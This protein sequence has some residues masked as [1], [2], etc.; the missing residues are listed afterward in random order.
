[1]WLETCGFQA[2]Q[3]S[4]ERVTSSSTGVG[5]GSMGRL[6]Q[7]SR[8]AYSYTLRAAAGGGG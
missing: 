8:L 6:A 2:R 1:M 7:R 3:L 4:L 5:G